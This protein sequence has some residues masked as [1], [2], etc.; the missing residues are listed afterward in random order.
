MRPAFGT[1][2]RNGTVE[3]FPKLRLKGFTDFRKVNGDELIEEIS[4]AYSRDG[5]EE[6]MII[7]R[8]NKRAT[9]YNN[10]IRNRILYRE[11]ELSSGDRLMIARITTSGLPAIRRWTS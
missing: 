8:S 3:I 10:G 5:I 7:S 9:L 1:P 11:E 4:S 2:L 6:T